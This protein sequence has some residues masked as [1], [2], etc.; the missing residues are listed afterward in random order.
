MSH[1]A[2][3]ELDFS[4]SP[5]QVK[6]LDRVA[7]WRSSEIGRPFYLAGFAGTG[8]TTLAKEIARLERDPVFGAFTAKAAGVMQDKGCAG[9][10]TIDS[11]IYRPL[12]ETRCV[13]PKQC[14]A[15]HC[16]DRCRHRRRKIV[17]RELNQE[18]RLADASLVI[19]DEV[20]MLNAQ[21]GGDLLSFGKP[22]LVLGDPAQ[23]PPV[24][25]GGYFTAREPD[26]LM[27][28]IHRQ[29]AG[30][31]VISLATKIRQRERFGYG[32]RDGSAVV[33]G[34]EQRRWLEFDQIIVGRNLTRQRINRRYRE[35]LGIASPLP[36]AG[37][38][39]V[40]LKNNRD[41]GLRNGELWRVATAGE[42]T[43][44]FVSLQ[45]TNDAGGDEVEVEAPVEG[46]TEAAVNGGDLDGHPFAYGYAI[47]C[48][49][50]QG[51]QW[52]KVLVYDESF[53]FRE[54]RWRWLYT[55]VTR[56][57]EAVTLVRPR[58]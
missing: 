36:V 7:E 33:R 21:M 58:Q 3:I 43:D 47:T 14:D 6:A 52:N 10:A 54:H 50:A 32:G 27:T 20:S 38:K 51:S 25:G 23:L 37:D 35:L 42:A 56:A 24:A 30:S 4:W 44:G 46:F 26:F 28:E 53:C 2:K 31:P 11:L 40:C 39:L 22:V 29:A 8:K 5:Q 34:I 13:A 49:K 45:I 1:V 9:A 16:P 15:P 57:A 48:H 17:G 55:A 19:V 12:F 18:S 41:L